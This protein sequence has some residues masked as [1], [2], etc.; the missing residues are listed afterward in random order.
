[1]RP[2]RS[3]SAVA[4]VGPVLELPTVVEAFVVLVATGLVHLRREV[5]ALL[6]AIGDA[7]VVA[8]GTLGRGRRR[9]A[10]E[11]P[12]R[13][14]RR[15]EKALGCASGSLLWF[16][17]VERR[18]FFDQPVAAGRITRVARNPVRRRFGIARA[19]S[20][21]LGGA[22]VPGAVIARPDVSPETGSSPEP[23]EPDS[24]PEPESPDP[25]SL[26][27]DSPEPDSP[28]RPGIS[29]SGNGLRQTRNGCW[30]RFSRMARCLT[31]PIAECWSP[32]CPWPRPSPSPGPPA[33]ARPSSRPRWWPALA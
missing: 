7:V 9:G 25:E 29:G 6:P 17:L 27:S 19:G 12:A 10:P 32:D 11:S 31:L 22:A 16:L 8:V 18:H 3:V 24:S 21:A 33:S 26:R 5:M 30:S 23:P 28:A 2:S 1:M 15:Q 20:A 4:R 13:R 14:E